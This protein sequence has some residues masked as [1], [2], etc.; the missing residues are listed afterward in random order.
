MSA[1]HNVRLLQPNGRNDSV[2]LRTS[3]LMLKE[4]LL[5]GLLACPFSMTDLMLSV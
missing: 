1:Y 4:G 2:S 3:R 5:S